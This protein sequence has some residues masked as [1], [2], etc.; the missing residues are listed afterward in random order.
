V[1]LDDALQSFPGDC[2]T[3]PC[4]YLDLQ[5]HSRPLQK[6]HVHPLIDKIGQRLAGWKGHLLN[7]AGRLAL[8]SSVLSSM[9]TYHLSIFPLAAWARKR[10]DKVRRS[11]LW[12]G[13]EQA[14][15]G[16][17]L[18]NRPTVSRPKN[19]GGLGVLDLDKFSRDLRLQW[20]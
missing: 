11:F 17:C 20:L 5:L 7:R 4:C 10:I 12:K 1:E 18:V 3:F 16:H 19:L 8:V 14:N 15:G 13:E 2:K 6:I 9:P